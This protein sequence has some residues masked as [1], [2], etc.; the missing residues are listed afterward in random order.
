[1][2]GLFS[3]FSVESFL[4]SN[5]FHLCR[6]PVLGL[7][8]K[9]NLA[10]MLCCIFGPCYLVS[11]EWSGHDGGVLADGI[12]CRVFQWGKKVHHFLLNG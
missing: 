6:V 9:H 8:I 11:T 2:N 10:W 7:G 5:L 4:G 12:V 3:K 1:M